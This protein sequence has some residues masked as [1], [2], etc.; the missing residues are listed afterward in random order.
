MILQ[1]IILIEN[2]TSRPSIMMTVKSYGCFR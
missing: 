1:F 2:I